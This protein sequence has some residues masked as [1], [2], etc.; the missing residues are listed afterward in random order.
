[1]PPPALSLA[2]VEDG[3]GLGGREA[4]GG[5]RWGPFPTDAA[6]GATRGIFENLTVGVWGPEF[7]RRVATGPLHLVSSPLP[8][9]QRWRVEAWSGQAVISRLQWARCVVNLKHWHV[10]L[11]KDDSRGNVQGSTAVRYMRFRLYNRGH[12]LAIQE[13]LPGCPLS[14][15]VLLTTDSYIL[16]Q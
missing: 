13:A 16:P 14:L 10:A 8:S 2:R 3:R 6:W 11:P 5:A 1:M 9:A 12:P 7:T 15:S 4:T